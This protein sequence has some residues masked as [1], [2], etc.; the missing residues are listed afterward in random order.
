[1]KLFRISAALLALAVVVT[2]L[3][4]CENVN[5]PVIPSIDLRVNGVIDTIEFK[6]D[7]E[8]SLLTLT[9]FLSDQEGRAITDLRENKLRAYLEWIPTGGTTKQQSD[10]ILGGAV[11]QLRGRPVLQ[12]YSESGQNIAV[13]NVM[14]YSGSMSGRIG[15]M[16]NAV[17]VFFNNYESGDAAEVIKFG[18]NIDV[19]QS[20]T[21]NKSLLL[22]AAKANS[23]DRGWTNLFGSIY[24][25]LLNTTTIDR[26][27]FNRAVLAFTD[28]EDTQGAASK[29]DIIALAQAERIPVFTIG[30]LDKGSAG[31]QDLIEIADETGGFY[32]F[33]PGSDK[34]EEIYQRISGNL[35]NS[36]QITVYWKSN[37]LPA[38]GTPVTFAVEVLSDIDVAAKFREDLLMP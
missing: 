31:E 23:F 32:Y 12:T 14:D 38:P 17:S 26:S 37:Q 27:S 22:T 2:G 3:Q 7:E 28:G 15:D 10:I 35:R 25:G 18:T 4:S 29:A 20:Y 33:S 21:T 1:M 30:L 8:E 34:L 11:K 16:E 9:M 36:Y 24:Q 6:R 19:V 5:D 13:S